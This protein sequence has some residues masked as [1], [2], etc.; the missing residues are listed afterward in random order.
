MPSTAVA[1]LADQLRS[2]GFRAQRDAI[3]ALLVHATK[4]RLSAAQFGEQLVALERREREAGNLVRRTRAAT[5]GTVPALDKFDWTHPRQ[6]D[7]A[8]YEQLLGLD[9]ARGAEKNNVLFRGQSGVG[10]TALAQNLG[11]TA[12]GRGLNVLFITLAAALADL[13]KQESLPALERRLRRYTSPDVLIIDEV[14][15]LPCDNRAA[16]LLYNVISRRHEKRA[17]VITTNLAFKQWSTIF[18]GAAC[19]VAMVDRFAQHC[20]IM[21]IDA[22]SWRQKMALEAA[23]QPTVPTSPKPTKRP[24]R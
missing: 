17:T 12:L 5:L 10:K 23:S 22:D 13:L 15:Y 14:G 8:L 24:K 6:I 9:F 20:Q 3:N 4:S 1:D 21:D 2:L 16:D 7:R 19:V 11:H 18:P